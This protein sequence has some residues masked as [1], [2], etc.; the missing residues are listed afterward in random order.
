MGATP[1]HGSGP[2]LAWDS[3]DPAQDPPNLVQV[4]QP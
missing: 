3:R 1:A 4:M 2:V